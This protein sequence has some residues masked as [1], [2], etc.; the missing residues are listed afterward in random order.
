LNVSSTNILQVNI[1]HVDPAT[2]SS[3]GPIRVRNNV[4]AVELGVNRVSKKD[5]DLIVELKLG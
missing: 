5:L 4:V 3:D 1:V 2:R